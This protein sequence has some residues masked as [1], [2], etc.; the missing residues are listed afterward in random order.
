MNQQRGKQMWSPF[1]VA[2]LCLG[3][4]T[5]LHTLGVPA[6]AAAPAKTQ[7]TKIDKGAGKQD[8][9]KIAE[10]GE[11]PM[12]SQMLGQPTDR[13]ITI[14]LLTAQPLECQIEYGLQSGVY[15]GRTD[16]I[17]TVATTPLAVLLDGL[18]SNMRY[19]YHVL[20]RAPGAPAFSANT[21]GTFVTQRATGSTF[22]F[23]IQGD[24]HPERRQQFSTELYLRTMANV[25]ARQ[26]DFFLTIGDDFS[27]DTL[28]KITQDNVEQLYLNQRL[29]L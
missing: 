11:A 2:L 1:T 17:K 12:V 14:S 20:W 16:V 27:V 25:A 29:W 19:Y 15:S 13:S 9:G 26:P 4:L 6:F 21:E 3:L 22:S 23:A 28:P 18:Q 8:G 5:V 24:S 10:A 7:T